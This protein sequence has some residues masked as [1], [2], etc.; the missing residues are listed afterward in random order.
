MRPSPNSKSDAPDANRTRD[1][2]LKARLRE[3]RFTTEPQGLVQIV[4]LILPI[5]A[6]FF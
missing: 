3:R 4:A 1:L 2:R 6:L 5:F